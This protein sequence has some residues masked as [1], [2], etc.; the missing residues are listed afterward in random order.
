MNIHSKV[1]IDNRQEILAIKK[2]FC[3]SLTD[4]KK[5]IK[6]ELLNWENHLTKSQKD[7]MEFLDD[8]IEISPVVP[9]K[10]VTLDDDKSLIEFSV[11]SKLDSLINTLY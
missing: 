6:A 11:A 5:K 4:L 1:T 7:V 3:S 8:S 9:S 2:K 10:A